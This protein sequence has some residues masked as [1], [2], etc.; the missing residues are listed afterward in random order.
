M[1]KTNTYLSCCLAINLAY[2]LITFF[3]IFNRIR[4]VLFELTAWNQ[5][6][7]LT[8]NQPKFAAPRTLMQ[9]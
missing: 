7:R 9:I 8:Y 5:Q 4:S 1:I 6:T 3:F 2:S